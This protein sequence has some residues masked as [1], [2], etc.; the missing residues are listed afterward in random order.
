M[1]LETPGRLRHGIAVWSSADWREQ[2][3]SWLDDRL[4]AAG[5]KRVGAVEQP[6]LRPWST[7]LRVPTNAGV[8][9]FKAIGPATAFEIELYRILRRSA[10]EQVLAPIAVDPARAWIV[11][12][13]GGPT[14][15]ESCQEPADYLAAMESA[16][17]RYAQLQRALMTEVGAL[18]ALGVAD[19]RAPVMPRRFDEAVDAAR[20]YVERCGSADDRARH[21]RVAA[22]RERFVAWCAEL[23]EAPV[24]PSLDHNDL[25]AWNIFRTPG[26]GIRFYD[27]GDSVVAHPFASMLVGLGFVRLHLDVAADGPEVLRVRDAY[28]EMFDDLAPRAELIRTM[29]LACRV[30]K[31]ARALTWARAMRLL[32]PVAPGTD[33]DQFASAPMRSL[34]SVLDDSYLGGA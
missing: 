23:A 5:L 24:P 3:V 18:L 21:E 20:D 32:G 17:R 25:H 22:A 1:N 33:D 28:L 19:M 27:W 11:L 13:D 15:G 26:A 16:V 8:A 2:A 9:W 4:D 6:H 30:G 7:V 12:P 14:L 29:E 31:A 10:P 34:H